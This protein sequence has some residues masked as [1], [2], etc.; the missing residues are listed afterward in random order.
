MLTPSPRLCVLKREERESYGFDVQ[1]DRGSQG[2]I[3]RNVELGGV[4][5]RSGLQSGDRLLEVNNCY[6]VSAPHC[7]VNLALDIFNR[8]N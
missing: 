7:E 8:K 4:A 6:V 3:I 2:H 1:V 5:G